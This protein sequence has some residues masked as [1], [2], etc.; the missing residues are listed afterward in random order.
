M[1]TRCAGKVGFGHPRSI[2]GV[3]QARLWVT[4]RF[5]DALTGVTE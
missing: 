5:N 4:W 3:S 1:V 2:G